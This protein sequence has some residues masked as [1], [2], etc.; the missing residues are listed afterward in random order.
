SLLD[1][2]GDHSVA[3]ALMRYLER[4][5]VRR[6]APLIEQGSASED[7]FFIEE[8]RAAVELAH[9]G[10]QVRLATLGHGAI[11]GEVAFYRSVPR[12]ASVVAETDL[13]AWRLSRA[14][15]E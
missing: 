3:D 1:V 12:S 2:V 10:R 8:G 13:V 9:G 15:L 6:G 11:A 4:I 14:A 5:E 7:L